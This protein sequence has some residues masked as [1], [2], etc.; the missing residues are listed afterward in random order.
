M[1][2]KLPTLKEDKATAAFHEAGHCAVAEHF[3]WQWRAV[4]ERGPLKK[5]IENKAF[6]GYARCHPRDHIGKPPFR[7]AVLGW[8][9][10][11]AEYFA[12]RGRGR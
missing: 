7:D 3:G 11:M 4:I 1:K 8:A 2:F 6:A 12:L 5:S 9:G 10:V